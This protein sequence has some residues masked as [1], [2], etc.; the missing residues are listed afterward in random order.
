VSRYHPQ[1]RRQRRFRRRLVRVLVDFY[2]G[3][4]PRCEYATT[5][6][7]GGLFIETDEPLAPGTLL[8]V[9]FRLPGGELLH[10]IEGRVNWQHRLEE[11]HAGD[12]RPSGMGIAFTD[13]A[14][15]ARL[16]VELEQVG[17]G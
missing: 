15:A 6:G 1:P 11:A 9:R 8:R 12:L 13:A 14:A 4:A 7:A 3:G 2:A 17:E 5:L 16:A 10:A